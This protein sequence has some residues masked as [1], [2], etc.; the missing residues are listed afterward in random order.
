MDVG[1]LRSSI[2]L[3]V[4][5]LTFAGCAESGGYVDYTKLESPA[6]KPVEDSAADWIPAPSN[7]TDDAHQVDK[8]ETVKGSPDEKPSPPTAPTATPGAGERPERPAAVGTGTSPSTQQTNNAADAVEPAQMPTGVHEIK[9]L[10][11]EKRFRTERDTDA[12]RLSYDDIDLMKVLNMHPVRVNATDY[13]PDW[14][15]ELD[16]KRVRILGFMYPAY[17]ATGLKRFTLTRDTG[18]CCF[19]PDPLLYFLI[20]VN[21]AEGETTNYIESKRLDVEGTF[22]IAPESDE[23]ELFRL[24]QLDDAK[25]L[26][27]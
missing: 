26:T 4:A 18:A 27:R 6:A 19:G 14:L 25:I 20:E 21:L 15:K 23:T 3:T 1:V 22:R 11:P 24:Y 16:G 5:A 2:A 7:P 9:L 12:I 17:K 8:P 13:F 10:V